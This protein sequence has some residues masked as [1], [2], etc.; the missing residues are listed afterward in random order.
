M[1]IQT[2]SMSQK[3][4]YT[5]LQLHIQ[6]NVVQIERLKLKQHTTISLKFTFST[7]QIPVQHVES[8]GGAEVTAW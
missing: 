4:A 1:G 7:Q 6:K 5:I 3:H 8:L 2:K